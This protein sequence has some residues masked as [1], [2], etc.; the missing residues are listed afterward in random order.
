LLPADAD[1]PLRG[2]LPVRRRAGLRRRQGGR[3]GHAV[4]PQGRRI[5]QRAPGAAGPALPKGP[6]RPRIK[7]GDHG[8]A[9][10]FAPE[11]L[12]DFLARL[13]AGATPVDIAAAGQ[14]DTAKL[15]SPASRPRNLCALATT[16]PYRPAFDLYDQKMACFA[17]FLRVPASPRSGGTSFP[18]RS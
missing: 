8:A 5:P 14:V 18:R 3:R 13:L 1:D 16:A 7:A 9:D 4:G 17:G 11:D 15:A 12:D 10:K 2:K 6:D